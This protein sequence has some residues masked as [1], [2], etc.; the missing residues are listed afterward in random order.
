M[1]P[2][3]GGS[4]AHVPES[5]RD[6]EV[7]GNMGAFRANSERPV[8]AAAPGTFHAH[9]RAMSHHSERF[10]TM[11]V[12]SPGAM[13]RRW[14]RVVLATMLAT[15]LAALAV[16][17]F[18][19][20]PALAHAELLSTD[21]LAGAV[22]DTAPD[23]VTL[24]FSE[25]IDI[26]LGAI[27]LF[28][29]SGDAVEVGAA[30]HPDGGS[31]TVRID[32][33]LL[34]NGSYVVDWRVVSADGHPIQGAFTF[35]VGPTSDLQAGILDDI[36]G[37][38][39]TGRPA[40][41]A[42]SVSRGVVIAAIAVVF[43][44]LVVLALGIV[45]PSRRT[46]IAMLAATGA[47]TV[48]GLV[49]LPL[50]VGYATGRS[51]MI[52]F[53]GDAWSAAWNSR[54]GTGWA[55]R[56]A[57]IAVA[58]FGLTLSIACRSARWWKV[59]TVAATLAVG[60]ASAYGG[61]GAAGRWVPIAI[62][63]TALHVAAMAVWLGG[64]VMLVIN[65][66]SAGA[67]GVRR[68]SNLAL[69]M[70]GLVIVSG[71]VQ[72]FRQLGSWDAL[73]NSSYGTLLI[74]KVAL[75]S[76]LLAVASLSRRLVQGH[77]IR[78]AGHAG[79]HASDEADGDARSSEGSETP[80]ADMARLRRAIAIEVVIALAIVSVTSLLMSSNPSAASAGRP[81]SSTLYDGDYLVSITV[82]PGRVGP[83][84]M[85]L[86]LQDI[87]SSLNQPDEI[88]VQITDPSREIAPIDIP[89]T[90]SGAGHF[91]GY[92]AT[93]P[94]AADWTLTVQARYNEFDEVSFTAVV[95]IG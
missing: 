87:S 81:F 1:A 47:G 21:P 20:S 44:G 92:D 26:G 88:S 73:T 24:T 43:G 45:E 84:E 37:S 42:L 41:I 53:D 89:V 69:A 5:P 85:H 50:E 4:H 95:P 72:S 68:F 3:R 14:M 59:A 71:V 70:V 32:L 31:S 23:A 66:A 12:K 18:S 48:F 11:G 64:L 54:I 76:L 46:R 52:V 34:R 65:L 93:F 29:G 9:G 30:E 86:Y 40:G 2:D 74:W 91:T 82:D 94:Y 13:V 83:N 25:G 39:H 78:A 49:L 38:D 58:G 27:R 35:Q 60:I 16:L 80:P 36:I 77:L 55:V 57:I 15:M 22:L 90:R 79:D 28:D 17:G 6:M 75:V 63:A 67:A 10:G 62:S 51:L 8:R 19:T 61:H 7:S 33:P 56:A